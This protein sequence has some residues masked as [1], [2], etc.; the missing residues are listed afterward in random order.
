MLL[1]CW[2]QHQHGVLPVLNLCA[3]GT[4]Q[5]WRANQPSLTRLPTMVRAGG[6]CL[7]TASRSAAIPWAVKALCLLASAV[8]CCAVLFD[9]QV[10]MK[11]S[12]ACHGVQVRHAA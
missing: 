7:M 10:T 12:L 1:L 2:S 11:Q 3:V 6:A 4:L 5:A 8:S 9:A